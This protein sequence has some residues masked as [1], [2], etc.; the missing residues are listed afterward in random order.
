MNPPDRHSAEAADRYTAV[1]VASAAVVIGRYS[2][3]FSLATRL[4]PR[5]VR[6]D[7]TSIYAL[8][9]VADE[10]VDGACPEPAAQLDALEC[11]T[12]TALGC[13]FSTNLVVHAFANTA[14]R[15]GFGT[16]LTRPF[17]ASMRTDL[18]VAAH[19]EASLSD[20]IH[21]S[22][23]AVGLMCLRSYLY[24][25]AP[26]DYAGLAPGACAL[27][28]AFQKINFLRDLADDEHRLGRSYLPGADP[29][30]L[31]SERFAAL[32]T[33]A[34]ADL[35]IG[36]A[37]IAGLPADVRPGVYAA[38]DVYAELLRRLAVAGVDGVRAGRIRVPAARKLVVVA[39]H[40]RTAVVARPSRYIP[41]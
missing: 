19:T 21:G 20:Y 9:R 28:S 37:N 38:S 5:R 33:D 41:G 3:S 26:Q 13:G 34:E 10:V 22:A 30:S 36:I 32:I 27:G 8:V 6:P 12:E 23:E 11:E 29:S 16:E 15:T 40:V 18:T 24:G 31:T 4:T 25:V 7:I 35:R 17:F 14:R 1:A 2:S 39:R